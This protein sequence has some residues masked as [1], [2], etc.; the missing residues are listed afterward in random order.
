MKQINRF[1][2]SVL[3]GV[4]FGNNNT[5]NNYGSEENREMEYFVELGEKV[6]QQLEPDQAEYTIL[7]TAVVYAKRRKKN[8]WIKTLKQY[9]L[10]IWKDIFSSVAATG[11]VELIK[12]WCA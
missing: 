6:L 9:S 12:Q 7:N 2:G 11:I 1:K 10:D 3:Q 8:D 4:A 5:I